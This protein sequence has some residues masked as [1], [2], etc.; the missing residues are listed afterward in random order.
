MLVEEV[1]T[2][3]GQCQPEDAAE[4]GTH[5]NVTKQVLVTQDEVHDFDFVAWVQKCVPA[6]LL[7]CHKRLVTC[8]CLPTLWTL[9]FMSF[10]LEL[11]SMLGQPAW[12]DQGRCNCF[13][14]G[15]TRKVSGHA[16]T[17]SVLPP[18]PA[19]GHPAPL[20][21]LPCEMTVLLLQVGVLPT[22]S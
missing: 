7:D 12:S 13:R 4:R 15:M 22:T 19:P 16:L 17:T 14:S 1:L 9:E 2:C 20:L 6:T 18:L 10:C 3:Q 8:P 21:L 11:R 5:Q